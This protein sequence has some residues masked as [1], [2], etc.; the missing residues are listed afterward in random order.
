MPDVE[1]VEPEALRARVAAR[2]R[3][4]AKRR[5]LRLIDLADQAGVSRG[6]L[7]A[8]LG[9]ESSATLDYL[10]RLARVLQVDPL[11]LVRPLRTPK[12]PP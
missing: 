9:G 10:C 11:E 12:S 6:Y 2:I 4:L 3:E 5:K 7:W 1:P 8:I